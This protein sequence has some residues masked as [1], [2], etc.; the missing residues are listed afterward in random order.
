[1]V[2]PFDFDIEWMKALNADGGWF[3]DQLMWYVS[4][5]LT[6]APLYALILWWVWRKHGWRYAAGFLVAVL[7]FV[8]CA[9]QTATFF[10]NNFSKFRPTHYPPL[11]GM[12][13]TVNGYLGGSYGTV[14]S[15]AALTFGVAFLSGMVIRKGWV[16]I[17]FAV[18][19]LLV[20]YS[21]IYLGV[22]YPMDIVLGLLNGLFWSSLF[23]FIFRR[24]Y[25]PK[26]KNV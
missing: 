8:L 2:T 26:I 4:A 12:L 19:I 21:R 18:W 3:V 1:M 25:V 9:D 14:S 17:C 23:Y 5:K 22:H 16:T 13:H 24:Y 7:L 11:E 15:H 6:W 10:K 20:C